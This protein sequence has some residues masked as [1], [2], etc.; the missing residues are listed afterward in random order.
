[1]INRETL[2]VVALILIMTSACDLVTPEAKVDLDCGSE[3]E[4]AFEDWQSWTKVNPTPLLSEGHK[5]RGVAPF[6]DVYVDDLAKTTYL[7]SSAPFPECARIVKAKYTDESATEVARL[8][9]MVKMP[10]GYDPE[11]NDWWYARYDTTGTQ[12]ITSPG[13]MWSDCAYCHRQAS[14]TDY[15]FSEDVMAAVNE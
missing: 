9:I 13:K 7:T 3:S 10:S 4:K 5:D 6:V 8:A 1:M 2:T 14:G 15:L 12:A 11:N